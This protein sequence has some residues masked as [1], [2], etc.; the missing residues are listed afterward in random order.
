MDFRSI[1]QKFR[2]AV[3]KFVDEEIIPNAYI[4]D[5]QKQLPKGIHKKCAQAGWLAGVI[6]PP[7]PTEYVGSNI[8]GGVRPEEFDAFH[9]L[10]LMDEL[11]R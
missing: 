9:E 7:W 4:W 10:I 2:A 5:E 1:S 6:G 8:A 11:L 3:R